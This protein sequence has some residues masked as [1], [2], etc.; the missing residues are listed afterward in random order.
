MSVFLEWAFHALVGKV[1]IEQ[2][3]ELPRLQC[4][5]LSA[6]SRFARSIISSEDI[7]FLNYVGVPRAGRCGAADDTIGF[8]RGT[9][10]PVNGQGEVMV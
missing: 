7:Y 2:S 6:E 8:D 3:G 1:E 9:A 4:T 5:H 10:F